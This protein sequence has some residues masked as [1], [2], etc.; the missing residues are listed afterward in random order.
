MGLNS[1]PSWKRLVE[2]CRLIPGAGLLRNSITESL[3]MSL[4]RR[5]FLHSL[6]ATPLVSWQSPLT[7]NWPFFRGPL[8]T[9]VVEGASLPGTWNAGDPTDPISRVQWRTGVPGLGH[10]S[11]ILWAD[12]IFVPTAIA[13]DGPAPLKLTPGGAP[14]AAEDN[15]EQRWVVLCYDR[16]SGREIWRRTAHSG[17]PRATR[18]VKATHANSTLATDGKHLVAFFGSEGVHCF[19]LDG[20]LLWKRDLG[21]VDVSKYGIGWGFASSPAIL[22]DN[23]VLICDDP[24]HPFLVSLRLSDGEEIWRADRSG[25]S[26]RSWGTP[27]IVGPKDDTQIV[28]NG[29]PWIV[30]YNLKD[31]AERWRLEGGGDNP[32]PTPFLANGWIYITNSHGGASPIYVVRPDAR[33]LISPEPGPGNPA[34][35]WSHPKGGSYM[36]TPVVYGD[37]LYFGN[38]NGVMR[39]FHAKTGEKIYEERLDPDAAIYASLVAGDGKIFCPSENGSVY[40]LQAGPEFNVVARNRMGEAC[41][42]TPIIA[43]GILYFRTTRSLIAVGQPKRV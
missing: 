8:G 5:N 10:G 2:P 29:W 1:R 17:K 34:M 22:G 26:E 13:K 9:G 25:V 42:A 35:V 12:R 18:H 39:C 11:P 38:T 3:T 16:V 31:G 24:N 14:T 6:I 33:G 28:V 19:D 20:R 27:L 36:S 15:G 43:D 21:V 32:A 4:S 23:L 41:Y 7:A 37:Y 30:S 40:V